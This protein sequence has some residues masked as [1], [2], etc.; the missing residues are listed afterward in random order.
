MGARRAN[1]VRRDRA[2]GYRVGSFLENEP[3]AEK[4]MIRSRG[5]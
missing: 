1:L 2:R 3:T 5:G 4:T